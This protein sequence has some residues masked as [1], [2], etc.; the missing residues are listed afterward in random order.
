[1]SKHKERLTTATATLRTSLK[2]LQAATLIQKRASYLAP[3]ASFKTIRIS[4]I[5]SAM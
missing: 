2:A 3:G 1:M 4:E 5:S